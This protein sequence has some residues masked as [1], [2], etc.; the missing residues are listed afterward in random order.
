VSQRKPPEPVSAP[1]TTPST[2]PPLVT[3]LA[4]LHSLAATAHKAMTSTEALAADASNNDDDGDDHDHDEVAG[5][6]DNGEAVV[7]E[8]GE[9]VQ[10]HNDDDDSVD[11]RSVCVRSAEC[12]CVHTQS[13]EADSARVSTAPALSVDKDA[14]AVTGATPASSA[15]SVI[16]SP[17]RTSPLVTLSKS[18]DA[19]STTTAD[20]AAVAVAPTPVVKRRKRSKKVCDCV[21]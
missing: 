8:S 9:G 20:D 16:A 7:D 14:A 2:R 10:N 5:A 15:S 17:L 11:A 19:S 18:T 13:S 4:S 1:P 21:G 6:V 3:R 12:D